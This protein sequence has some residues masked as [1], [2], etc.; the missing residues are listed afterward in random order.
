[1][2]KLGF[3]SMVDV[4][5]NSSTTIFTYSDGSVEPAKKLIDEILKLMGSELKSDDIFFIDT[6]VEGDYYTEQLYEGDDSCLPEGF[7]ELGWQEKSEIVRGIVSESIEKVL[8]GDERPQWMIDADNGQY[9][10]YDYPT[11][12]YI[13]PKDDRYIPLAEKLNKF[14]YSTSANAFRDG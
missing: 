10:Y 11:V 6:F 4:I 9:E 12:L 13:T 1:M 2:I 14:L 5:T 8:R 7:E 3:H